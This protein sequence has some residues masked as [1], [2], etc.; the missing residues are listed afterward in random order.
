M[1]FAKLWDHPSQALCWVSI[2]SLSSNKSDFYDPLVLSL[3]PAAINGSR[4]SLE[5]WTR[6]PPAPDGSQLYGEIGELGETIKT[7][8]KRETS[9]RQREAAALSASPHPPKL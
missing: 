8:R 6:P 5:I 4:V 7:L 3:S 9:G 1:E 2:H